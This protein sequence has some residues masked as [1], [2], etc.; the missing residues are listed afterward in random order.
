MMKVTCVRCTEKMRINNSREG[1]R[2]WWET[3]ND[4]RGA[5]RES[6]LTT[7]L[8]RRNLNK[9][10]QRFDVQLVVPKSYQREGQPHM[11]ENELTNDR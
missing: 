10:R 3:L 8:S 5:P 11:T 7:T 1:P 4:V 2:S 6:L 9:W